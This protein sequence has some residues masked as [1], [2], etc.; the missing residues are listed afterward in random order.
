MQNLKGKTQVTKNFK[1]EFLN[2]TTMA[3]T[4]TSTG[5]VGST[6]NVSFAAAHFGI[7]RARDL[8]Y[9]TRSAE[10]IRVDETPTAAGEVVVTRGYAGTS[11][12]SITDGDTWRRLANAVEEWSD[13][14]DLIAQDP[15]NDFNY[16]QTI[17]DPFGASGHA[18]R[19]AAAGGMIG[20]DEMTFLD[21]DTY[22]DHL[23]RC[24]STLLLGERSKTGTTYTTRGVYQWLTASGK[25]AQSADVNSTGLTKAILDDFIYDMARYSPSKRW[26]V[27]CGNTLL[28]IIDGWQYAKIQINEQAQKSFGMWV[29]TYNSRHG[30]LNLVPHPL[31]EDL[32]WSNRA[33][34]LDLD[35]FSLKGFSGWT[36]SALYKG[37]DGKGLQGNGVDGTI[38]EYRTTLGTQAQQTERCGVMINIK[39]P[40]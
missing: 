39:A 29:T 8:L 25:V 28:N 18:Q 37:R 24:E 15:G 16:V 26:T 23:L 9:N 31:F 40:S 3:Q 5:A 1:F 38:Y 14:G 27:F 21:E 30:V 22:R 35:C 7:L 12:A 33:I 13:V 17:R 20:P 10:V 19:I 4:V 36:D 34:F 32:G 6:G 11:A 2:R